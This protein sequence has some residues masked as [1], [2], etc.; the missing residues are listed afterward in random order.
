MA[1]AKNPLKDL[2]DKFMYFE[3]P[4]IDWLENRSD[5][6]LTIA[7]VGAGLGLI[8]LGVSRARPVWKAGVFAWILLP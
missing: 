4:A 2:Y 6:W 1:A 8:L 3:R 5:P 7:L